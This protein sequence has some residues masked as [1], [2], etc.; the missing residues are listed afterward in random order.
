MPFA[1]YNPEWKF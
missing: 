1:S